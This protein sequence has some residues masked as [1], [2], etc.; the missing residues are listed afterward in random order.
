MAMRKT[1]FLL[2]AAAIAAAPPAR[3]EVVNVLVYN[4]YDASGNCVNG[5]V[6]A[7]EE[8]NGSGL[9]PGVEF[10]VGTSTTVDAAALS[11][12][13][14][15]VMPGGDSG[16][17]YLSNGAISG[18][19]IQSFVEGGGGYFGTC[20]GAYAAVSRVYGYYEGWGIAPDVEAE[21][22]E[23]IGTLPVDVTSEGEEILGAS[24]V[25][26]LDH[27]RGAAMIVLEGATALAIFADGSTGLAGYAAI[28][29]DRFGSGRT[30]L[31]GPHPELSPRHPA[32]VAGMI[33][34]A[35]GAV[36][37]PE[38]ADGEAESGPCCDC[39]QE[40]RLCSG[41]AWGPWG[42]C[43]GPDPE[44]GSRTCDTGQPGACAEGFE[45]CEDGCLVCEPD[46]EPQDETCNDRDDD[47][48]GSIDE[49][50]AD[51]LLEEGAGLH[52]AVVQGRP[53]SAEG[54]TGEDG[55]MAGGAACS[56][57]PGPGP[58]CGSWGVLVALLAAMTVTGV[59]TR[60]R[61]GRTAAQ[62]PRSHLINGRTVNPA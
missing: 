55:T 44:G 3:G 59:R 17:S 32:M 48:D 26:T 33:A 15:L 16:R 24:G 7:L 11:G 8:A 39:G 51:G 37:G 54:E 4:G 12:V 1:A 18:T 29:A 41:G 43:E 50:C 49:G 34:W 23:Y 40:E 10:A 30:V 46:D 61:L 53:G 20:A 35:A 2:A 36:A 52:E 62:A 22:V 58:G 47:C 56:A 28:A 60:R 19:D 27:Y 21:A 25:Q 9:V 45:R 57:V 31:S 38:C 5:T 13:D 14:V 6:S 42:A